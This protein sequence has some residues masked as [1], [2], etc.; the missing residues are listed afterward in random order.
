M[1]KQA[2]WM[3]LVKVGSVLKAPSGDFRVVRSISRYDNGDLRAVDLAIRRC[4]WTHRA[5]TT[6]NYTDLIQ[7]GFALLPVRVK[8]N[9]ERD[10]MMERAINQRAS[11]RPFPID[12]CGARGMP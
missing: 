4:S 7:R 10:I 11:D 12:C 8:L 3:P 1:R 6:V 9:H 2:H 5:Y